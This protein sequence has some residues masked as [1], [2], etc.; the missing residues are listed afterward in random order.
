[1]G[2]CMCATPASYSVGYI[3]V[4]C[5]RV[6]IKLVLTVTTA[7]SVLPGYSVQ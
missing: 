1:M 7:S 4:E 3:T 6:F 2:T 5:V